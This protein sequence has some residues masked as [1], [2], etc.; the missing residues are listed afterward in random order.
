M[1][2]EQ[3]QRRSGRICRSE[4]EADRWQSPRHFPEVIFFFPTRV[5]VVVDVFGHVPTEAGQGKK[6]VNLSPL[7]VIAVFPPSRG[8][9]ADEASKVGGK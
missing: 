4:H 5:R 3:E 7:Q 6:S 2:W 8:P 1:V 9:R